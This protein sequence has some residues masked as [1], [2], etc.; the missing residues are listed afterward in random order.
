VGKPNFVKGVSGNPNGRPKKGTALTDIL[1]MLLDKPATDSPD[2][3]K[4][5]ELVMQKLVSLALD[6]DMVAIKYL[7]DRIDGTPVQTVDQNIEGELGIHS[8]GKPDFLKPK[9]EE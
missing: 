4:V 2:A 7:S 6:G 3:P 8:I 1:K 9:D 5:K